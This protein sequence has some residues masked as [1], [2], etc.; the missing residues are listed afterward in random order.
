MT[1]LFIIDGDCVQRLSDQRF[2]PVVGDIIYL[3]TRTLNDSFVVKRLLWSYCSDGAEYP[4]D[5][6]DDTLELTLEKQFPT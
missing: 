2:H 5:L 4:N 3:K 1:V 6:R